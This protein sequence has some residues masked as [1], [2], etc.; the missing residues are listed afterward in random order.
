MLNQ[1]S[2]V[3]HGHDHFYARQDL[4]GIVYQEV[5]QPGTPGN[6][7]VPRSAVEYGYKDGTILGGSGPLRVGIS[8]R[9]ATVDYIRAN[10]TI[11]HSH[12]I[13][14]RHKP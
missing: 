13:P 4:D 14:A 10:G 1:V 8:A 12:A 3:F 6:N 9:Q 7:A 5:T 11:A 2:A